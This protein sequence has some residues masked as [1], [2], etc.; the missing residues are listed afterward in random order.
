[1]GS[2]T[3]LIELN[4]DL[5]VLDTAVQRLSA[6]GE[7][8]QAAL[9]DLSAI[10]RRLRGLFPDLPIHIDL[11]ELRGYR[12]KTG[13]VFAAFVPGRG[14]EVAR[15]GRYDGVGASF[16]RGRPAT[17]FSADLNLLVDLCANSRSEEIRILAP[18]VEDAALA[19]MIGRLRADGCR[20][21]S[22][23]CERD[24]REQAQQMGCTEILVR[25]GKDW[26]RQSLLRD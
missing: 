26:E 13:V 24:L 4:G 22:A 5:D 15:G 6:A 23:L 7:R 21:V 10:A 16:G 2:F 25:Q 11:A 17:G 19:E 1:M 12:Y 8:V 3:A 20:V 9:S 14:R 18:A